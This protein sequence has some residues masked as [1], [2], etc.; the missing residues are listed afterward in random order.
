MI[1]LTKKKAWTIISVAFVILIIHFIIFW[2][3][4]SFD[5][6]I[7]QNSSLIK[8]L[9][10]MQ[11]NCHVITGPYICTDNPSIEW[12]QRLRRWKSY[13]GCN[14]NTEGYTPEDNRIVVEYCNCGGLM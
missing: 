3:K 5:N 9:C 2:G 10:L 11:L 7:T 8:K 1:N 14:N 4:R 13:H 12:N 6:E